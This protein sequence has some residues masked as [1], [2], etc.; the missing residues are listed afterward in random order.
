MMDCVG[1]S[2][3]TLLSSIPRQFVKADAVAS[4]AAFERG[5]SR[6]AV[7]LGLLRSFVFMRRLVDAKLLIFLTLLCAGFS[8]YKLCITLLDEHHL[9]SA[10]IR[11]SQDKVRRSIGLVVNARIGRSLL[12]NKL[13]GQPIEY[14]PFSSTKSSAEY[15]VV[16][17]NERGL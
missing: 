15:L 7:D 12:L 14:A 1:R 13:A 8:L 5:A 10:A 16:S 9:H 4:E 2:G 3:T 11:L 17:N 6:A